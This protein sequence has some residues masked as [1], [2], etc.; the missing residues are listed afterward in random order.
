MMLAIYTPV[1]VPA[2]QNGLATGQSAASFHLFLQTMLF[3]H[4]DFSCPRLYC[5]HL[6]PNGGLGRQILPIKVSTCTSDWTL[7]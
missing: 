7:A 4:I 5:K 3:V 1:F 6:V 2:P